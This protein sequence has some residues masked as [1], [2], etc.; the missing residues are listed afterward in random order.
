MDKTME[1]DGQPDSAK[2]SADNGAAF[3]IV[4]HV[5]RRTFMGDDGGATSPLTE[6]VARSVRFVEDHFT[7]AIALADIA[8]AAGCSKFHFI[9]K[10]T[11]E[12][13]IT[14]GAF[15]RGYRIVQAMERLAASDHKIHDVALET[16]YDDCASFSR[17]FRKITGNSPY[18]Y[19]LTHPRPRIALEEKCRAGC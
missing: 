7:E 12:T 3:E 4:A 1:G 6:D 16:G 2:M 18:F 9:R 10:F 19:R 5:R 17:A 11:R 8:R 14:P 15:L 13:A